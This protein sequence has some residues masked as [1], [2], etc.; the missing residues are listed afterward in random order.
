VRWIYPA[1]IEQSEFGDWVVRFR[2]V[3]EALTGGD[4][5]E[6]AHALAEDCLV[7]ALGIYTN[8]RRPRPVPK[9]SPARPGEHRV[10]LPPLVAAKLALYEAMR[11]KG[12]TNMALAQK[13][14]VTETV[15]R[16][17]LDLDHR[18]HI[19]QVEKALALLGKKLALEV[20]E[21]A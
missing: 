5:F 9:P 10:D 18:S 2:D 14:G 13:L 6:E 17:L 19:G 15:V 20:L 1:S 3:P 21:R 12:I 11:E 8:A 16:R 4:S 7:A